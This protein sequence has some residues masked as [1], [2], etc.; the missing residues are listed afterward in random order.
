MLQE[1]R[2]NSS[3][4]YHT[5]KDRSG[6]EYG[7]RVIDEIMKKITMRK[8]NPDYESKLRVFEDSF[9]KCSSSKTV[10]SV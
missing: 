2:V 9:S 1:L 8:K 4:R 7:L 3:G 6:Y 10:C 5:G